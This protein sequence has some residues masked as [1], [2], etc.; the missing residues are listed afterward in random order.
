MNCKSIS[1]DALEFSWKKPTKIAYGVVVDN[2]HYYLEINGIG[3]EGMKKLTNDIV[4]NL[5]KRK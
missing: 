4:Y 2:Y 1:E 3:T 5:I